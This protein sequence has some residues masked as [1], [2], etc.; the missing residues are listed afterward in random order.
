MMGEGTTPHEESWEG[1]PGVVST[2]SPNTLKDADAGGVMYQLFPLPIEGRVQ[3]EFELFFIVAVLRSRLCR[4]PCIA[5]DMA[6]R[7]LLLFFRIR[8]DQQ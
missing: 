5:R 4:R 1:C 8:F 3:L 6:T 2:S 7:S